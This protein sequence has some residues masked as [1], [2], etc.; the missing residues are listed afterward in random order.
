MTKP[1]KWHV[2]PAKTDQPGHLPSLIRV[3]T[4]RM[5]KAWF[6]NYPFSAQQSKVGKN[7]GFM[8]IAQP[9]GFYWENPGFIRVILGFTGFTGK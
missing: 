8:S 3:F 6:L 4:V 5:K 7:P 2:P 9:S 1:T